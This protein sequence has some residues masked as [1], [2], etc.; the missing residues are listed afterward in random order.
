MHITFRPLLQFPRICMHGVRTVLFFW[1]KV[2]EGKCQVITTHCCTRVKNMLGKDNIGFQQHAIGVSCN[3][4]C[5]KIRMTLVLKLLEISR[6]WHHAF[7]P[8][9]AFRPHLRPI[10]LPRLPMHGQHG[11]HVS[12]V[13]CAAHTQQM[14]EDLEQIGQYVVPTC[15]V[16]KA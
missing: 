5:T 9:H 16:T 6:S 1:P 12:C 15:S 2:R 13:S 3:K 7:Q 8:V 14:S 10:V 4:S 11:A